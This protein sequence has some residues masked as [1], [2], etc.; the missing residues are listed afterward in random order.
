MDTRSLV[1]SALEA[2]S[3][4]DEFMARLPGFDAEFD[5]LRAEAQKDGKVLRYVGVI[6]V[7]SKNIR[8]SLEKYASLHLV[9]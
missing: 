5:Q 1:P 7:K 3:N 8:A 4:G 2:V 9:H 6:D